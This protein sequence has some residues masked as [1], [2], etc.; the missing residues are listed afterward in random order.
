MAGYSCSVLNPSL[1]S[2]RNLPLAVTLVSA[3]HLRRRHSSL[4]TPKGV[5]IVGGLGT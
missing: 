4:T 3:L 2:Q 5:L 1:V